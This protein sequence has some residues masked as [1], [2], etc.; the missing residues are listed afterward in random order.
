[1]TILASM[2][3]DPYGLKNLVQ[4]NVFA[5]LNTYFSSLQACL[6]DNVIVQK[7][8]K[9]LFFVWNVR[10]TRRGMS[11]FVVQILKSDD[12]FNRN[13][14]VF[15]YIWIFQAHASSYDIYIVREN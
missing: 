2:H 1:M 7:A 15:M 11:P 4:N 3:T 8:F 10:S 9:A 12:V 13:F 5:F 6:Q 14:F